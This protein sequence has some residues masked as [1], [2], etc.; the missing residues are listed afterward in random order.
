MSNEPVVIVGGGLAGLCAARELSIHGVDVLVLESGERVGGRVQTDIVN[1]VHMDHG[2]QLYNTGYSEGQRV[3]DYQALDLQPFS[4]GVI[5]TTPRGRIKLG[6]PR[7]LVGWLPGSIASGSLPSKAAF[8]KY[9]LSQSRKSGEEITRSVD[10]NAHAV[11]TSAGITGKFYSE[12]IQ[13]FFAGV[14]LE[15]ELETSSR[16]MNMVLKTFVQGKPSLP[17]AGMRAIPDQLANAL[18]A[19]SV[20]FNSAVTSI[21]PTSVRV[22]AEVINAR[23]VILAT[24]STSAAELGGVRAP[25]WNSVTT[26]YHLAPMGNLD[27]GKPVIVVNGGAAG[28][29]T[30]SVVLTNAVPGYAH[31]AQLISTSAVG[32]HEREL[33]LKEYLSTM[34]DTDASQWELVGHYPIARALPAMTPPH[35]FSPPVELDGVYVAGDFQASSSIQG[36]MVSGRRAASAVLSNVFGQL[37]DWDS[38]V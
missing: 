18:P 11:L 38:D 27:E 1:G 21:S 16:F 36:A 24:D 2:F 31:D 5:S 3:L 20:R 34:H 22:G 23:A 30:N 32:I 19:G 29:I 8:V 17:S 9:A 4:S 28:P 37:E 33:N 25:R 35:S 7:E 14:F 10:G 15:S 13:P 6:D 12:V 26:W